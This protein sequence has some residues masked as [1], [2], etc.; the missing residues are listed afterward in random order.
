MSDLGGFGTWTLHY[1]G[2]PPASAPRDWRAT[3]TMAAKHHNGRLRT[4][5]PVSYRLNTEQRAAL[6]AE[7]AAEETTPNDCARTLQIEGLAAR[8]KA[9]ER[10][11][12]KR[13]AASGV[14]RDQGN[15]VAAA[16]RERGVD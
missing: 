3:T 14:T 16:A 10:A 6:E 8:V 4:I 13:G 15:G 11:T 12:W 7:A 2:R 5:P 1:D 9:R